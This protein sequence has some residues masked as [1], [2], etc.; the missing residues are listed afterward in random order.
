MK[1]L[2]SDA[3]LRKTGYQIPSLSRNIRT[4]D[5]FRRVREYFPSCPRQK[6]RTSFP[7]LN[8]RGA[9]FSRQTAAKKYFLPR[10]TAPRTNFSQTCRKARLFSACFLTI[11]LQPR[12]T[13]PVSTLPGPT[14][15]N[16][17]TPRAFIAATVAVKRTG[18]HIC[19]ASVAAKSPS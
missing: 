11:P 12:C 13:S 4:A 3:N 7:R 18:E 6:P 5:V 19:F 2:R 17:S 16:S 9:H 14:S 8:A 1:Q 10:R 15:T